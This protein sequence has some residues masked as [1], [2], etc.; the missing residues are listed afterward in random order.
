L[1]YPVLVFLSNLVYAGVFIFSYVRQNT[2]SY[3]L[4]EFR[5]KP[6]SSYWWIPNLVLGL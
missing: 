4:G 6:E 5:R 3:I 2:D 1:H